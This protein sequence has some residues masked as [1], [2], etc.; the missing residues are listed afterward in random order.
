MIFACDVMYVLM[1]KT[2]QLIQLHRR[3]ES[4]YECYFRYVFVRIISVHFT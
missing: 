2:A 1:K 4:F 3:F